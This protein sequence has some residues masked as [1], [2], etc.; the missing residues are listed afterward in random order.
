MRIIL[1]ASVALKWFHAETDT[2]RAETIRQAMLEGT[3]SVQVPTLIL[4]EL[5]NALV[6]KLKA[7]PTLA[8]EMLQT[9]EIFPW[10]LV[11]PSSQLLTT[12]AIIASQYKI[13]VYDA[14]YVALAL[15]EKITLVTADQK[16]T[17][18]LHH[19][20]IILLNDFKIEKTPYTFL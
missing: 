3:L 13:S 6:W 12:A 2:P 15:R 11:P 17:E 5:T 16:L 18:K 9:I 19:P 8:I 10:Y 14:T 1:D 20:K 7:N 4:Y